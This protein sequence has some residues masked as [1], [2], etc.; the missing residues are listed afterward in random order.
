MSILTTKLV[1]PPGKLNKEDLVKL[2]NNF[3]MFVAPTLAIFF[4]QLALGVEWKK[5]LPVAGL[6]LWQAIADFFRNLNAG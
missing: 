2:F 4:G 1:S 6:A 5:A 3:V